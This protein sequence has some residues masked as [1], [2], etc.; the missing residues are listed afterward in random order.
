MALTLVAEPKMASTVNLRVGNCIVRLMD[1]GEGV[2]ALGEMTVCLMMPMK[3][4]M[5]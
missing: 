5:L 3:M 1:G 4:K 2:Q